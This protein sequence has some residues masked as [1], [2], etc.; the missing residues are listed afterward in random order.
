MQGV[1]FWS[2]KLKEATLNC[3]GNVQNPNAQ[4]RCEA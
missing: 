2:E 1:T 4:P 3:N